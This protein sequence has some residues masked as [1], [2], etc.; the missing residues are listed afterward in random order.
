[1]PIN[2]EDRKE[3]TLRNLQRK[4]MKM[5]GVYIGTSQHFVE[6]LSTICPPTFLELSSKVTLRKVGVYSEESVACMK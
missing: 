5:L 4:H 6:Q 2:S 1:M 3:E